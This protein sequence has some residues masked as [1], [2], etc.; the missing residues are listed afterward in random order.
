MDQLPSTKILRSASG[1]AR[2]PIPDY[3]AFDLE[4]TG[5]SSDDDEIV[6][7]AFVRFEGGRHA[8]TWS[9]FV[10]PRKPVPLK[11]LR[12]TNIDKARLMES[13]PFGADIEARID[14]FRGSL[15][16]VGHNS[17]FD[18]AFLKK[19]MPH[20]PGVQ[21]YDTLELA[22]IIFAGLPSY[23]LA[24][25]ASALGVQ[26][27]EAH[28]AYDDAMVSGQVFALIQE[29]A[30]KMAPATRARILDIMGPDWLPRA[31]FSHRGTAVLAQMAL[32]DTAAEDVP[33]D[34]ELRLAG[35]LEAATG[36][37][38]P[39]R[40]D[41]RRDAIDADPVLEGAICS[42]LGRSLE[43]FP[44]GRGPGRVFAVPNSLRAARS[45]ANAA[46]RHAL[47]TGEKVLLVGFPAG[48]IEGG[49]KSAG[50]PEDYLCRV[51]LDEVERLGS[52]GCY[53]GLSEEERRYLSSVVKW[54]GDT[55]DGRL[56]EVQVL[57][58]RN[59]Q[60]ELACPP[61]MGC[62]ESCP[63]ASQCFYLRSL[64]TD[65]PVSEAGW[66]ALRPGEAPGGDVADSD[67]TGA[68]RLDPRKWD[69]V[70]VWEYQEVTRS[71]RY[72]EPKVDL[73]A[74]QKEL[75][76]QGRAAMAPSLRELSG[77][78][79]GDGSA[80]LCA[81]LSKELARVSALVDAEL[82]ETLRWPEQGPVTDPPIL[83]S[84][85]RILASAS[86]D[87]RTVC[88][89]AP[90]TLR[91]V[92]TGL[93]GSAGPVLA[94]R[95]IWP[96]AAGLAG[97]GP[98]GGRVLAL[99]SLAPAIAGSAGLKKAFAL[100]PDLQ[101]ARLPGGGGSREGRESVLMLGLQTPVPPAR[102]A[103]YLSEAIVAAASACRTGLQVVFSS[104]AQ[105]KEVYGLVAP[106]LEQ[107][108]IVVYAVGLDG[109][110]RVIEN[111]SEENA[112][113]FTTAGPPAP[114]DPIP[115]CLVLCKVPFAP[116]NALD[117]QRRKEFSGS[118]HDPFVEVNV[119]QAVLSVRAHVQRMIDDGKDSV[120]VVADPKARSGGSNWGDHFVTAFADLQSEAC[121]LSGLQGRLSEFL[122]RPSGE[123][124]G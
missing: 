104:R 2:I 55:C 9:T 12:L 40:A 27:T 78:P 45:A 72:G 86:R 25:L 43:A 24:E 117:D 102:Y 109:G 75:E 11:M 73:G 64:A 22:R 83:S 51:R 34:P 14:R 37:A 38:E 50:L 65:C 52:L 47:E 67:R 98:L 30:G 106:I 120:F 57:G 79:L 93:P 39:G 80:A 69:K 35:D 46:L 68:E 96:G 54:A 62:K 29:A 1:E 28:R 10:R 94:R 61:G 103:K 114:Q 63:K 116:P 97:L 70:L 77:R 5:L 4:T 21:V 108:G 16:L 56:S 111:L 36:V 85:A 48:S 19:V 3:V 76:A 110:H 13:S 88:E 101:A 71:V 33:Q 90:A 60:R 66:D 84:G 123:G 124:L 119:R 115:R 18:T 107:E 99:S 26:V 118:G 49:I 92:E 95:N 121:V 7:I 89:E 44:E 41:P 113:V 15:P 105:I 42:E 31:I 91:V 59:V 87:L 82:K 8:E 6:E 112:V 53:R 81:R 32:F 20:F 58:A 74:L 122:E 100:P 17:A 23:R